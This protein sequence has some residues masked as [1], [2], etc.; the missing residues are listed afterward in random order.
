MCTSVGNQL[1]STGSEFSGVLQETPFAVNATVTP[2]GMPNQAMIT[3]A[4]STTLSGT[5]EVVVFQS[6]SVT[7]TLVPMIPAAS[8]TY[9]GS[10]TLDASFFPV[11]IVDVQAEDIAG[12]QLKR[13]SDFSLQDVVA[14]TGA[15][16]FSADG[17]AEVYIP[18]GGLSDDTTL[19]IGSDDSAG[20][21]P[22]GKVMVSGPYRVQSGINAVQINTATLALKYPDAFGVQGRTDLSSIQ[23]FRWD[24]PSTQWVPLSS[25]VFDGRNEVAASLSEFGIYAAMGDRQYLVY[26]PTVLKK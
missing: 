21:P 7:P 14:G 6:G 8:N 16:A 25:T 11:G 20:I 9:T 17:Q 26:L 23:I 10:F 13:L 3:L 22:N 4:A 5:P 18:A 1:A 12:H 24:Q 2:D 19:S 15:S